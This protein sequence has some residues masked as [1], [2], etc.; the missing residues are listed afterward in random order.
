[1]VRLEQARQSTEVQRDAALL[2][3]ALGW[4]ANPV[5][6]RRGTVVGN[7]IANTPGAEL[8]AVALALG[9]SFVFAGSQVPVPTDIDRPVTG[10]VTH[11]L[12]PRADMAAGFYEVSRRDGHSPVVCA[13]V[14]I[15]SAAFLAYVGIGG[16]CARPFRG[17]AVERVVAAAW[18]EL[19]ALDHLASALQRDVNQPLYADVQASADYRIDVA[20]TVICRAV[21]KARRAAGIT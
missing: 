4:V 9:A 13:G 20:P 2:G 7:L 21:D 15:D 16:V 12:W 18:P 3:A 5:I 14:A 19:P 11:V 17:N 6:R 1:L 10:M 8:P